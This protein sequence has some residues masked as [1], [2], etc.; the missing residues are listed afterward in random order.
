MAHKKGQGSSSNGRDSNAQRRGVKRFGGE[1]VT[2][3]SILVQVVDQA[4]T[5]CTHRTRRA[6]LGNSGRID[7]VVGDG[8]AEAFLDLHAERGDGPPRVRGAVDRV[9]AEVEDA[10]LGEARGATADRCIRSGARRV[11]VVHVLSVRSAR[12]RKNDRVAERDTS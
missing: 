4:R 1:K 2:A 3:G 5:T 12:S 10:T 6:V 7:D 9:N 8:R 11:V